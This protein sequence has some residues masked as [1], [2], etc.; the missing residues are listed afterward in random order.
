MILRNQINLNGLFDSLKTCVE[1]FLNI[2]IF[3]LPFLFIY[4]DSNGLSEAELFSGPQATQTE[5]GYQRRD[6]I[7]DAGLAHFQKAYP[8]EKINKED[9]FYYIYGLLH[10]PDYRARYADNLSKEL[11]RIPAVKGAEPFWAFS[12]AGRQLADLHLNYESVQ[13]HPVT[14]DTGKPIQALGP[15]E[16]RVVKMKFGKSKDPATGKTLADKTT[17]IYNPH[18]TLRDIPLEAYTYIVN[19]KPAI[20]WVM[21]RQSVTTDKSS[22]IT[23]D[24]NHY[25]TE[26]LQNPKYPLE[27]LQ[28][29]IT[30]SLETMKV[31]DGLPGMSLNE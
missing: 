2:G 25:A 15:K 10:S 24:A 3:R 18:I 8:G 19:G 5:I 13:P 14:L 7:S 1:C 12:R 20:E 26:T 28:R 6:G 23:N 17:I 27:L 11:P 22:Q 9:L 21:E 16:Y 4:F 29:I 31:V 30:V